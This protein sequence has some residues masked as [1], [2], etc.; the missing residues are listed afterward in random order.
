MDIVLQFFD[1]LLHVDKY[2]GSVIQDYGVWVY[3]ILFAIVFAET[4]LIVLP[5]LPGDSL[6]FIGGAFCAAGSLNEWGLSGLL[7][8]AAVLGNTVNYLVGGWVGPKVFDHHW[9]FLDQKALR[10]SHDFYEKHGGKMLVLARFVPI[11]RTFAPF[12]A[13]VS[14]MTFARFQLFNV[15]G[16]V[17]WVFGLVFSGYFFGNLPFVR[18]YL[19]L[20]VLAGICAAIVPLILGAI[21]KVVHGVRRRRNRP[22]G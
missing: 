12:V 17:I 1:M 6:L 20:I 16:A 19:N 14:Q 11:V 10:K 4:G 21:W 7:V 5:F 15:L 13:G 8:A 3:A 2:L 22:A 9:R 18:Q